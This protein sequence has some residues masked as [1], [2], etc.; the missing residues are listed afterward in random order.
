MVGLLPNDRENFR[1]IGNG[2]IQMRCQNFNRKRSFCVY[3]AEIWPKH[4]YKCSAIAEI[5]V[6]EMRIVELIVGWC[7]MSLVIAQDDWRD[8]RRP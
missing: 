1:T 8:D 2:R 3:A 6:V 4:W 7:I 5:A